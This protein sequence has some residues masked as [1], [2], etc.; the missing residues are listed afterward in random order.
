M[1]NQLFLK[2][3][4]EGTEASEH[5]AS[6]LAGHQHADTTLTVDHAA[7][8]SQSREMFKAVV[9]DAARAVFQGRITVQPGA[10]QTDARMMARALLL[11]DEAVANCK[12]ELEIF[13]DDV[14]ASHGATVG[15][16]DPEALFYLRQRGLSEP[17]A[18]QVL[19][20][21][22]AAEMLDPIR[23][24]W[25]RAGIEGLLWAWLPGSLERGEDAS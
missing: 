15:S 18:R 13:A 16:L 10:Q 7:A 21:G 14:K 4:G 2:L 5:Q 12:P 25:L 19:C 23:V 20:Y 11:S 22:F 8:G 6:L 9:D 3:A 17:E 1:R 24:D